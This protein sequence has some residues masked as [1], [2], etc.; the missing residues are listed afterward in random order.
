MAITAVKKSAKDKV[1]IKVKEQDVF[2]WYGVN[3]K[4]KKS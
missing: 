3:R 1:K 4:G 2:T